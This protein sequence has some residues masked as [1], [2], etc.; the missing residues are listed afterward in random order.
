MALHRPVAPYQEL[1]MQ[2]SFGL[3]LIV[4]FIIAVI[5]HLILNRKPKLTAPC[6]NC[7]DTDVVEINRETT[8]TRTVESFGAGTGAGG[9]IRLQLDLD[10]TF[11]CQNCD[12]KFTRTFTQ[13]Q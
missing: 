10:L 7:Q 8:G 4:I 12:H 1:I 2:I 6:P 13:T 11:R 5:L 3:I 9:N